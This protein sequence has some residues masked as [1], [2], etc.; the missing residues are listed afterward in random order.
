MITYIAT[1]TVN[2]KFYI[3]STNNFES[4]K[5]AHLR[6][7]D[8]YPFQNALRQDPNSFKW[9]IFEDYTDERIL[10]QA[11]LDMYF[12]TE[13]CYN[14]CSVVSR[15]PLHQGEN[16]PMYGKRG[17]ESPIYRKPNPKVSISNRRRKGENH[18]MY[19]KTPTDET[20]QKLSR[21]SSGENNASYG[22]KWWVSPNGK[23]RYQ[24]ECPGKEWELGTSVKGENHPNFG[25]KMWINSEGR[26]A[27]SKESPGEGWQRG[28]KWK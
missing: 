20:K 3:G 11:L 2:G 9:E 28:M 7:N 10:E 5:R 27:M 25:K 12:G 15:P 13:Q 14:I 23:T 21:K 26:R 1:N 16:H 17:E 4:R 8:N 24:K 6:S 19:G 22:K 18:P